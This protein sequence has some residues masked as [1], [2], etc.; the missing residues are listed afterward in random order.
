VALATGWDAGAGRLAVLC[1]DP[2]EMNQQSDQQSPW[3]ARQLV[4]AAIVVAAAV[5]AMGSSWADW[6]EISASDAEFSQVFLVVPFGAIIL[7][8]DRARFKGIKGEASWVGPL[9]VASGWGLAW[10]GY[11]N[12]HQS[13]WHAGAVLVALGAGI[14]VLGHGVLLRFLPVFM[15]LAF[16]VPLSNRTRLQIAEPLQRVMAIIV[17]N[18]LQFFGEPVGRQGNLL[19]VNG[20]QV[21]IAEA[22]NGLR[23][24]F[25][26][27]LVC[28]LFAFVTPLKT[29]VRW[30]I[31]LLSP[32][33][34]LVCNIFRLIPTLVLYGHA[35]KETADWFH[36]GAGWAMLP[37][38]FFLLML[39]VHT[40]EA[41]GVEVR[42]DE[43]D[44]GNGEDTRETT[45]GVP[46]AGSV[47]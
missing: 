10:Y 46:A 17:A 12:A 3:T 1:F 47:S 11:N 19:T 16:M 2:C 4:L 20:Q 40:I 23:M 13:L 34:A 35:S 8:V 31:I 6:A 44:S 5:L 25:T 26:L 32:L 18:V 27:I 41:F 30:L 24:V 22:C 33:T 42:T 14:A 29:W 45:A 39:V 7:W 28:W 38:A 36:D 15:M 9:I 21:A 43:E 37:V